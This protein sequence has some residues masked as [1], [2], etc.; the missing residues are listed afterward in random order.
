MEPK[1]YV[2]LDT[3]FGAILMGHNVL[4]IVYNGRSRRLCGGNLQPIDIQLRNVSS[5]PPP[6]P[7]PPFLSP[8]LPPSLPFP[9]PPGCDVNVD[10]VFMLDQSGSVGQVDHDTA[11]GFIQDV[12]SFFNV[13]TNATQVSTMECDYLRLFPKLINYV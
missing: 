4:A 11:L 6:P 2:H 8:S 13:S 3:K 9:P 1:H 12:V 10:L 5:P 7:P